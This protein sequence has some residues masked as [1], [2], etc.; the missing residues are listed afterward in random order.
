M[1]VRLSSKK[2]FADTGWNFVTFFVQGGTGALLTFVLMFISGPGALGVFNQLYAVYAILGQLAA[3]GLQ[4]SG[5]KHIAEFL[6]K[7]KVQSAIGTS[8]LICAAAAGSVFAVLTAAA[9]PLIGT[10]TASP[11]VGAGTLL[12]A[13]GLMFFAINKAVLGIFNG[14]QRMKLYAFGHSLRAV[15]VV[16]FCL[17]VVFRGLP[18]A[19]FGLCFTLA[20]IVLTL[21]LAPF[22]TRYLARFDAAGVRRWIREHFSFGLRSLPHGFFLETFLRIDILILALFLP[23][24]AVG[25]YSFAAFFVEGVFQVPHLIRAVTN[26]MLVVVVHERD[27]PALIRTSLRSMGTSAALTALIAAA[28]LILY[29][30]FIPLFPLMEA[31]TGYRLL[32]VLLA[33]LL[34]YSVFIP[35][36]NILLQGGRPGLQ[37][38]YR[39]LST[40]VN[41]ALNFILIPRLGLIG[42]AAATAVSFALA[43]P[44]V[45]WMAYSSFQIGSW[46]RRP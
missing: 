31:G 6:G 15:L 10:A 24:A 4:D 5:Q 28:V 20:E 2:Y 46:P 14:E 18:P 45:C 34:V 19:R 41:V 9:S 1:S 43:G 36:D 42:A 12:L 23:D 16:T 8:N 3:F 27:R 22:L 26:P 17:F 21:S 32:Q 25:V 40:A 35:I 29:P 30:V 39:T 13:P 33:G 37:S 7:D 38:L 44:L 11:Q